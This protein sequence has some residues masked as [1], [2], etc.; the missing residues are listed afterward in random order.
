MRRN[1][2]RFQTTSGV[3]VSLNPVYVIEIKAKADVI[4]ITCGTHDCLDTY[5]TKKV[6]RE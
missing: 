1:W 6:E 3:W 2:F 4:V 5:H